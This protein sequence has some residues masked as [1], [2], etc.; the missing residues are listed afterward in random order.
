[1]ARSSSAATLAPNDSVPGW[2]RTPAASGRAGRARLVLKVVVAH[3]VQR[4]HDP[5]AGEE[6]LDDLAGSRPGI[7]EVV[8]DAVDLPPVVHGV[9]DELAAQFRR[10]DGAIFAERQGEDDEVGLPGRLGGRR[11]DRSRGENLDGESDLGRVARAGYEHPVAGGDGAAGEHGADLARSQ[12]RDGTQ[13]AAGHRE[14]SETG[15]SASI[16]RTRGTTRVP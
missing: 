2:S 5:R 16:S 8:A 11:G 10:G 6:L 15:C 1:M 3:V 7:G 12:D 4:L 9:D 13:R 14:P